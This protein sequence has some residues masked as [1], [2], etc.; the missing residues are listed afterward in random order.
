MAKHMPCPACKKRMPMDAGSCPRCGH[1]VTAQERAAAARFARKVN[2]GLMTILAAVILFSVLGSDTHP[3]THHAVDY[4]V[5]AREDFSVPGRDRRQVT[6]IAASATTRDQFAHTA[7]K[8]AL[9]LAEQ[10]G[11]QVAVAFLEPDPAIAGLG[12]ALAIA[13]HAPDSGGFSG[14]QGWSWQVEAAESRP[15]PQAITIERLWEANRDRFQTPDG[16]GSTM[17]DEPALRDFIAQTLAIPPN[18]V[19]LIY[20][21]RTKYMEE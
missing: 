12:A 19:R 10:S 3:D 18:D 13:R 4:Q 14:D 21:E 5:I 1:M 16:S 7:I 6:I 17:T 15:T 11:T 8:A 20:T 9:A 2:I